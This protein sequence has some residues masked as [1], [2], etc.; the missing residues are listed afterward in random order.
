MESA[1]DSCDL[2]HLQNVKALLELLSEYDEH[3]VRITRKILLTREIQNDSE[4]PDTLF[5][6]L[7]LANL[8]REQEGKE[9]TRALYERALRGQEKLLGL[10]HPETLL[11]VMH[12]A[13]WLQR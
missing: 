1:L 12:Y 4:H 8:L 11:T 3:S 5:E 2:N 10:E 6:V 7:R 9:E 13:A